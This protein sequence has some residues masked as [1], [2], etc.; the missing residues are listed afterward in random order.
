MPG[1]ARAPEGRTRAGRSGASRHRLPGRRDAPLRGTRD[2][3]RGDL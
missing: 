1:A 3:D 2:D